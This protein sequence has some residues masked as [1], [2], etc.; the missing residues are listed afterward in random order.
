MRLATR[1]ESEIIDRYNAICEAVNAAPNVT[2]R[3]ALTALS[4]QDLAVFIAAKSIAFGRPLNA[5]IENAEYHLDGRSRA[6][7]LFASKDPET[8]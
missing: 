5:A 6:I 4:D 3:E 7:A 2:A 8:L 1:T